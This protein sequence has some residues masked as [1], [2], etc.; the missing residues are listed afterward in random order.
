[1]FGFPPNDQLKTMRLEAAVGTRNVVSFAD[2]YLLCATTESVCSRRKIFSLFR[3]RGSAIKVTLSSSPSAC[4]VIEKRTMQNLFT[5]T[6]LP[7]DEIA[8]DAT[9][10]SNQHR[11]A[12]N[13]NATALIAA[14]DDASLRAP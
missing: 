3:R 8:R 2:R 5:V 14:R 9:S 12:E 13:R 11:R 7:A 10:S 1:M 4:N 6:G